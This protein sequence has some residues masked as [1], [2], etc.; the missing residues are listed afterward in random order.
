MNV[1]GWRGGAARVARQTNAQ[2]KT[3]PRLPG[4]HG[5]VQAVRLLP[6]RALTLRSRLSRLHASHARGP[7]RD[8]L[9]IVKPFSCT[10]PIQRQRA[11]NTEYSCR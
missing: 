1:R 9:E 3:R 5:D 7:D 2:R 6:T 10:V 8:S 4:E 11:N